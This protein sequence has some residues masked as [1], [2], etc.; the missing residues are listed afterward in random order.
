MAPLAHGN[1]Y[2]GSI[3]QPA[4]C[5]GV[6]GLRPGFGRVPSFNGTATDERPMTIQLFASQGPMARSVRDLRLAVSVMAERDLRDPWW[7]PVPLEGPPTAKRVALVRDPAGLGVHPAI[8]DAVSQAGRALADAGY[9][10]VEAQPP[11]V[12]E[13]AQLWWTLTRNE[14]RTLSVGSMRELGGAGMDRVIDAYFGATPVLDITAYMKA[15]SRVARHAR[16][17]SQFFEQYPIVIAPVVTEPPP[18]VDFDLSAP[19]DELI[20]VQ[21]MLIA[22][23]VV[24]VPGLAVPVTTWQGLPIGVQVVAARYREDLCLAAG[25]IIEQAS[26]FDVIEVLA[27][28]FLQVEQR[29]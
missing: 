17:W 9:E 19:M 8:A 1:D 23:N 10:V 21:R 24:G 6:A 20:R 15:L 29:K 2:G 16:A 12:D 22:V 27:K 4:F 11:A 13:V 5:C 7:T 28:R 14:L 3:R 26:G 25:E 18:L